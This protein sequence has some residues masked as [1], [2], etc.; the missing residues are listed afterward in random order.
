MLIFDNFPDKQKTQAF[1][2]EITRRFNL[3]T[4]VHDFQEKSNKIDT[5]PF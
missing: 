4:T 1:A 3:K 2:D 5:F